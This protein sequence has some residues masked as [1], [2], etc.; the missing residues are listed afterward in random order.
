M[1]PIARYIISARPLS[2][3][4]ESRGCSTSVITSSRSWSTTCAT[5]ASSPSLRRVEGPSFEATN[6]GVESKGVR[7]GVERRRARCVGIET[8]VCAERCA[9]RESP[10][11]MKFTA[12]TRSYGDRCEKKN[13]PVSL[14]VALRVDVV[15]LVRA[16]E[17]VEQR[18]RGAQR[19]QDRVARG[20]RE[21]HHRRREASQRLEDERALLRGVGG[22]SRRERAREKIQPRWQERNHQVPHRALLRAGHHPEGGE[23]R[24]QHR[25][26]AAFEREGE[27][28]RR[29]RDDGVELR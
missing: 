1:Y 15:R 26:R 13:A 29:R 25:E 12:P 16:R 27:D 22:W 7:G 2:S 17:G 3:V 19:R 8:E 18:R 21:V 24:V 4:A 28:L 10:Q 20:L 5:D 23:A 9:G 11:G 14:R 6:V